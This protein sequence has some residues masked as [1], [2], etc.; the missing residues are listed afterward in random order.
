M[1][2]ISWTNDN[3]GKTLYLLEL[4]DVDDSIRYVI[5]CILLNASAVLC[6]SRKYFVKKNQ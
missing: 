4:H 6:F 5:G 2:V 3:K 1:D